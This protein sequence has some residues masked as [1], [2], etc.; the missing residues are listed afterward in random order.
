SFS[1]SAVL[2]INSCA[3]LCFTEPRVTPA[4]L[5]PVVRS[6]FPANFR[7]RIKALFLKLAG[8]EGIEPPAFGFGD[9]R[10]SQLSYTPSSEARHRRAQAFSNARYCLGSFPPLN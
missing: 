10:S 1:A 5:S 7:H 3:R 2:E 9:R 4:L 6:Q 8:V